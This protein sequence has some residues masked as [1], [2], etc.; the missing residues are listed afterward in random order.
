M[1]KNLI[2]LPDGTE[3][4]SG[5][6][7]VNT[8]E[9]VTLTQRVNNGRTLNVGS[10]CVAEVEVNLI[11]PAGGLHISP[12]TDFNLYRVDEEGRRSKTGLFTAKNVIR[13]SANQYKIT[14]YDR[15]E[16]LDKNL[17]KW[18]EREPFQ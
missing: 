4:F 12:G 2:I 16:Q 13:T 7:E 15:A 6:G 8:I 18:L 14:A 9:S 17:T 10:V 11:T 5:P 1:L 3:I